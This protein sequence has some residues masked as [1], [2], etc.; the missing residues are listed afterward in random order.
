MKKVAVAL[1]ATNGFDINQ[2]KN[3]EN[4]DY[5]HVDV[6]DGKFVDN[7]MLNLD[8]F[9]ALK[10]NFEIPI[11]A[12]MMVQDPLQYIDKIIDNIDAF[13]FHKE[14][15]APISKII[16]AVKIHKKKVGLV[17]NPP[18][19][20]SSLLPYLDQI[21]FVLIM[22]VNPGWSA[23]KFIDTTIEKVNELSAYKKEFNFEIDV[24]GGVNLENASKLLNADILSS[25]S[26]I[27]KAENP[28]QTIMLL[29]NSDKKP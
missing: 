22:G 2:I 12:H 16:E 10:E 25:S 9:K 7:T 27:L 19:E 15:Q 14:I 18:T 13:L 17:I 29:K 8:I 1:H 5:I 20:V 6:M 3:L 23:Q 4:L 28:N 24:D 11:I 21:D 26:T